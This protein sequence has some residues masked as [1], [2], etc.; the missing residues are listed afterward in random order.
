MNRQRK[1]DYLLARDADE[2]RRHALDAADRSARETNAFGSQEHRR[3]RD[4]IEKKNDQARRRLEALPDQE[5][6]G[7]IEGGAKRPD[8][9]RP[10]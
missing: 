8:T 6:D 7:L 3:R 10:T 1:I 5:L 9:P 2:E 4:E